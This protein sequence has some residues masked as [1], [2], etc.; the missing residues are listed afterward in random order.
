MS[1]TTPSSAFCHPGTLGQIYVG[2]LVLLPLLT[3]RDRLRLLFRPSV[4]IPGRSRL[5]ARNYAVYSNNKAK[6]GGN[7]ILT[8]FPLYNA[9]LGICNTRGISI[10]P[11]TCWNSAIPSCPH[12]THVDNLDAPAVQHYSVDSIP[13]LLSKHILST[14]DSVAK[15]SDAALCR[16]CPPKIQTPTRI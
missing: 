1:I 12:V 8:H 2:P 14:D 7:E 16:P 15:I 5:S 3:I 4:D 9:Y 6:R 10:T 11:H 13:H